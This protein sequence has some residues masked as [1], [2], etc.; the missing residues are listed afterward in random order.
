[1]RNRGTQADAPPLRKHT[2]TERAELKTIPAVDEL[3]F[4]QVKK[5]KAIKNER[6]VDAN[7]IPGT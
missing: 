4:K 6:K 1:M 3:L 5:F 7:G 2:I